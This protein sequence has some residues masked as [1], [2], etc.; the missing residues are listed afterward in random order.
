LF[1]GVA[2]RS[3]ELNPHGYG[4]I[5][6]KKLVLSIMLSIVL[7]TSG[8]VVIESSLVGTAYACDGSGD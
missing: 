5:V 8:V 3:V 2:A 6:M 1:V 7:L 4:E